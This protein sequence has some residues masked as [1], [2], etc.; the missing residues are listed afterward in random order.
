MGWSSWNRFENNINESVIK[1]QIDGM[2]STGMKAA[3]YQYINLDDC[4]SNGR[5]ANGFLKVDASK[6]PNGMKALADYAH[7]KGLKLGIY[8]DLG[9]STCAGYVRSKGYYQKDAIKFAEWGI[10]YVKMDWCN[11]TG[12]DA[13]TEYGLFRD[14]LKACGRPM[15]FSICEWGGNTPWVWGAATGNLW[16][17]TGDIRDTWASFTAIMDENNKYAS[18]AK[19]G[20]WNDPDMLEVGNYGAGVGG[21]GMTDVEYK[22]HFSMW[23][24]M[25][26]PLIAGNDISKMNQ[27]TKDI[28]LNTEVIAIDQDSLGKR[29]TKVKDYG[30]GLQV[31]AKKLKGTNIY[32]V[33]LLN[34]SASIAS[35]TANWSD[36]GLPNMSAKVRDLWAKKDLG[37]FNR[38]LS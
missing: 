36:I 24:L 28:L 37:F 21:G 1:A 19:P 16:R 22:T 3:G 6:F 9:T 14:A 12:M 2:V 35:V 25:A 23:A 8:G 5:D 13:K 26:A 7:S 10:D 18:Y 32:A 4:W 17:T 30:N 15:V 29:G 11:T 31:W 20:T 38:P 33:V 27:A 34:R